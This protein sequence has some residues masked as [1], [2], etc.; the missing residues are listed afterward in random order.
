MSKR[1]LRS[2]EL[3]TCERELEKLIELDEALK[4]NKRSMVDGERI[5]NLRM[6]YFCISS[7]TLGF[8]L[9]VTVLIMNVFSWVE[10]V[11][12]NNALVD[13]NIDI[14]GTYL[15]VDKTKEYTEHVIKVLVENNLYADVLAL[16]SDPLLSI[17]KWSLLAFAVLT[18]VPTIILDFKYNKKAGVEGKVKEMERGSNI[19]LA[20]FF[21]G[22]ISVTIF[23][24]LIAFLQTETVIPSYL[25]GFSNVLEYR[26][27]NDYTFVSVAYPLMA[28]LSTI[29]STSLLS[30]MFIFYKE[31]V[32]SLKRVQRSILRKDSSNKK[33][34]SLEEN[35]KRLKKEKES[36]LSEM[37]DSKDFMTALLDN[38]DSFKTNQANS[39]AD[40]L[41]ESKKGSLNGREQDRALILN[42]F[43]QDKKLKIL[44]D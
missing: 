13:L 44:N 31:D 19:V 38:R 12:V 22:F 30:M 8:I 5:N 42:A 7:V 26:K 40:S 33:R 14:N 16:S 34:E 17:N 6:L 15:F 23:A 32:F 41:I 4:E 20:V 36:L 1:L 35:E 2:S 43:E 9:S 37:L 24:L 39:W 29:A 27:I 10:R 21:L 3:Y 18:I 11:R 28:V 25:E